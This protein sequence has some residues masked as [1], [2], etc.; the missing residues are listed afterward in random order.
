MAEEESGISPVLKQ[1]AN[2]R[3]VAAKR[4]AVTVA[5]FHGWTLIGDYNGSDTRSKWRCELEGCGT[6]LEKFYS[7]IRG[8][9]DKEGNWKPSPRHEGCLPKAERE[10]ALQ[11]W[12]EENNLI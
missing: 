1:G 9:K 11:K 12:R 3:N 7:H 2:K 10:A 4:N 8:R 6:V 5:R